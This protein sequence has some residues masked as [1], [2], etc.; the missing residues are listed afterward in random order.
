MSAIA[1]AIPILPG[2]EALDRDTFDEMEGARRDDYE[3][4]LRDAGVTRHT[5]WHQETPDGTIAIVYME[6]HDEAGAANFA[7]SDAPLNRWFRDR[8]KEVHGIDISQ[9][10][11]PPKQVH[12]IR[13]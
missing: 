4:A 13:V 9:A 6:S 10:G 8:M 1:F 3:A 12:D 7:S 5:V 11:P 2:K